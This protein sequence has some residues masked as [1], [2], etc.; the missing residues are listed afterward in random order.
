MQSPTTERLNDV[1][2]AD[3]L[4]GWVIG[5]GGIFHTT[6]GGL[7]WTRQ[8]SI[9]TE[10]I[11]GIDARNCWATNWN[12]IYGDTL[13]HT[14]DGGVTWA[15]LSLNPFLDSI[16]WLGRICFV[17][18]FTGWATALRRNRTEMWILR[19]TDG[20]MSWK[21]T[22]I[23]GG[24]FMYLCSF[25][26][27][28]TGW[29][30]GE[31]GPLLRTTDGGMTWDSLRNIGYHAGA[32]DMQ[33]LS[34]SIGWITVDGPTTTTAIGKTADSGFTFRSQLEFNCSD[35]TTYISFPDTLNGWA[36]QYT[37][38]GNNMEVW[39]TSDGGSNWNL[40]WTYFSPSYSRPL[41]VYFVDLRHGCIVGSQGE[42]FY[43]NNG[44]VTDVEERVEI[45]E[46]F[47]IERNYPNPFNSETVI[48]YSIPE[49]SEVLMKIYNVLGQEVRT[50]VAETEEAGSKYARW[51]GRDNSA[52]PVASGV[53]VCALTA[54]SSI[55]ERFSATIT[56]M[57][58]K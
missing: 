13:L 2:F 46:K 36:V 45:P 53:Y 37:C 54:T 42:I 3:S 58:L 4:N 30:A 14:T 18:S 34:K 28:K 44:G 32:M 23:Q 33:F 17:D 55:G 57:Y 51:D 39:H 20:G 56:M 8:D 27:R 35:F 31:P 1:Y 9:H 40:Q 24:L 26:D 49:R 7:S 25:V 22:F 15:R 11:A 21:P 43:T 19:T 6:N 29:V 5:L 38:L 10:H 47:L 50:L 16:S 48:H 12:H 41:R 52:I